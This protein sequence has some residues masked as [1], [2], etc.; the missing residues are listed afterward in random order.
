MDF[1]LTKVTQ[2]E[3][4]NIDG[5]NDYV[6]SKDHKRLIRCTPEPEENVF[7]VG[8]YNFSG[9]TIIC[10]NACSNQ[11]C[12]WFYLDR[13]ID[14]KLP[15]GITHIG[16][17]AFKGRYIDW[18]EIPKSLTYMGRD[19][20]ALSSV[21]RI[22][23]KNEKFVVKDDSIINI[24]EHKLI[25]NISSNGKISI[26]EGVVE[27]GEYSFSKLE[28]PTA[29]KEYYSDK[30]DELTLIIPSSV[31]KIG[32]NAFQRNN[33]KSII[34]IGIPEIIGKSIFE[35]CTL[36]ETIY[37]PKGTKAQFSELL[38]DFVNIIDDSGDSINHIVFKNF[39]RRN[40]VNDFYLVDSKW[41][42][43]IYG[44]NKEGLFHFSDELGNEL[45]R[46][47]IGIPSGVIV[48]DLVDEQYKWLEEES[49]CKGKGIAIDSSNRFSWIDSNED[50]YV[51]ISTNQ[52]V[53]HKCELIDDFVERT[54]IGRDYHHRAR[55]FG[56]NS[57]MAI[58]S[59]DERL[60]YYTESGKIRI[61]SDG[62]LHPEQFDS[63]EVKSFK[64]I[65]NWKHFVIVSKLDKWGFFTIDGKYIEPKYSMVECLKDSYFYMIQQVDGCLG[66]ANIYGEEL[67]EASNSFLDINVLHGKNINLIATTSDNIYI[68]SCDYT[69]L[70]KRSFSYRCSPLGIK[71]SDILKLE[72]TNA[73]KYDHERELKTQFI[74]I[75]KKDGKQMVFDNYGWDV[76]DS[77][78]YYKWEE[79]EWETRDTIY[80]I[81]PK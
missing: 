47:D 55:F 4:S 50:F 9:I 53:I 42:H 46:E 81:K 67:L 13:I 54:H 2:E 80:D 37:V 3:L 40:G 1:E 22:K 70:K 58:T 28:K 23:N 63:I 78:E 48:F 18:L 79:H 49:S 29:R 52:I 45:E 51:R 17:F 25:H 44:Y 43:N 59:I 61:V 39:L 38:P 5:Y 64:T 26:P 14:V 34:F 36:L 20:F 32:D 72:I 75:I 74:Y 19:P 7:L 71:I 21:H 12:G 65:F 15:E 41:N 60:F 31:Q 30:K 33:L 35:E 16:D 69:P 11:T 27:I 66:I 8:E 57:E 68:L 6:Y 76:T 62:K 73:Y 10:D 77:N 56:E 24:K